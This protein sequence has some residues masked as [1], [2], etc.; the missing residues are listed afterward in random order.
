VILEQANIG[1]VV[2]RQWSCTY[3]S[4]VQNNKLFILHPPSN[5]HIAYN[6]Y[7]LDSSNT[8]IPV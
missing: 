8:Q 5:P 7:K 1:T 4:S 6:Q 2:A 3:G